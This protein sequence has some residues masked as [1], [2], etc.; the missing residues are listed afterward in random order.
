MGKNEVCYKHLDLLSV[1]GLID[2]KKLRLIK[3]TDTV[4]YTCSP[5]TWKA[6]VGESFEPRSLSPVWTT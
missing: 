6:E 3:P 5:G 4:V 1:Q 2:K